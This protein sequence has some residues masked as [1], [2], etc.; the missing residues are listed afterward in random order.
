[1]AVHPPQPLF[2]INTISLGWPVWSSTPSSM[3]AADPSQLGSLLHGARVF[4]DVPW[5][6]SCSWSTCDSQY[7]LIPKGF[8][9]WHP[10]SFHMLPRV[11][12]LSLCDDTAPA[13][14]LVLPSLHHL[15]LESRLDFNPDLV[16]LLHRSQCLI[17]SLE[18]WVD[19]SLEDSTSPALP[20][21]FSHPT[22]HS[23]L[24]RLV[25]SSY[26]LNDLFLAFEELSPGSIPT[27]IRLLRDA[28][29]CFQIENIAG[30]TL[31]ATSGALAALL[32]EH[33]H[34]M[35]A[36]ELDEHWPH[37]LSN[38]P[39]LEHRTVLVSASHTLVVSRHAALRRQYQA[40]WN[41]GDGREVPRRIGR[42][43]RRHSALV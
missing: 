33:F 14:S 29:R 22:I 32:L 7:L 34:S 23:S 15:I 42:G 1:M 11:T 4:S 28:D 27:K 3:G 30:I 5:T 24:T 31:Q 10:A 2:K 25:I 18:L 39:E 40:W 9:D 41:S 17:S 8:R 16:Q 43:G 19:N 37:S 35:Q 6:S 21:P 20:L 13:C 12:T 38:A 36:L 26:D